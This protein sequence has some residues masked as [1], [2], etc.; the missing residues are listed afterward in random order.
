MEKPHKGLDIGV[1]NSFFDKAVTFIEE[2]IIKKLN[3]SR[4][5]N[6]EIVLFLTKDE[7]RL[8]SKRTVILTRNKVEEKIV[9]TIPPNIADGKKLRLKGRGLPGFLWIKPGDILLKIKVR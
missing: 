9:V 5:R 4:Y 8:G 1:I 2:K 6:K 3:I 7:A